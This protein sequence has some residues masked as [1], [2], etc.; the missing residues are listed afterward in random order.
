MLFILRGRDFFKVVVHVKQDTIQVQA[1]IAYSVQ[2][3]V[4]RAFFTAELLP[5]QVATPMATSR[6]T[7]MVHRSHVNPALRDAIPAVPVHLARYVNQA[8]T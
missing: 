6:P 3:L 2:W 7:S 1:D 8:T 4:E 5:A